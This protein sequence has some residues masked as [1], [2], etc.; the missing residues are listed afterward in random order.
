MNPDVKLIFRI[1]LALVLYGLAN[2]WGN[3]GAFV[4]PVLLNTLIIVLVSLYFAVTTKIRKNLFVA[5]ALYILCSYAVIELIADR[6]AMTFI[7]VTLSLQGQTQSWVQSVP[8]GLSALL[9]IVSV[10]LFTA[11]I[12]SLPA[13]LKAIKINPKSIV[14]L[15]TLYLIPVLA[16]AQLMNEWWLLI[17]WL[18]APVFIFYSDR[19]DHALVRGLR[20]FALIIWLLTWMDLLQVIT[21]MQFTH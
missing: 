10:I 4:P 8:D 5:G 17:H 2:L 13:S 20:R 21:D 15:L 14:F 7:D 6:G 11:A 1:V 19:F 12:F 9:F 16:I 18:A 3:V